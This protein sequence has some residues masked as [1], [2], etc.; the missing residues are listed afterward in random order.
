MICLPC[1]E[2]GACNAAAN[3]ARHAVGANPEV[4]SIL[5]H[6]GCEAPTTCPCQH[7]T[8]RVLKGA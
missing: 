8:G 5:L 3:A 4:T 1:R 6:E 2:G 7:L